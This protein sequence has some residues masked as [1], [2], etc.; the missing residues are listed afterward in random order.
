LPLWAAAK[1]HLESIRLE[2]DAEGAIKEKCQYE[3][4]NIHTWADTFNDANP[5]I[6]RMI[7]AQLLERV[8]VYR[9]YKI[10]I[11]ISITAKQFFGTDMLN[12]TIKAS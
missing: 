10:H 8:I 11:D 1:G 5:D 4:K 9:G 3:L 6:K 12:S 2:I 7:I